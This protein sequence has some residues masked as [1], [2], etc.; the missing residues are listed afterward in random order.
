MAPQHGFRKKKHQINQILAKLV[1]KPQ[2]DMAITIHTVCGG[3][4][5]PTTWHYIK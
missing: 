1:L 4:F 3:T 5:S 2:L